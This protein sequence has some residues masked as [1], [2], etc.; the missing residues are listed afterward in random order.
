MYVHVCV[1]VYVH[2]CMSACVCAQNSFLLCLKFPVAM[3][4]HA[5][6]DN[7]ELVWYFHSPHCNL[8]PHV[9]LYSAR[10]RQKLLL[11]SHSLGLERVEQNLIEKLHITSS[12]FPV[13]R[14]GTE[15][16]HTR[17]RYSAKQNKRK[18]QNNNTESSRSRTLRRLFSV[19]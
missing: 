1:H 18:S 3:S 19:S 13:G 2:M 15:L 16:K 10:G 12:L 14:D 5:S 8:F 7:M 17:H 4:D 11:G 6:A 9:S